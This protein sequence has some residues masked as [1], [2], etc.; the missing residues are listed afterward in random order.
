[1]NYDKFKK[2][3]EAFE[4]WNSDEGWE[5]LQNDLPDL[6]RYNKNNLKDGKHWLK[7]VEGYDDDVINTPINEA[8]DR[9]RSIREDVDRF[10]NKRFVGPVDNDGNF[11][12]PEAQND[13]VNSPAHYT[14]GTQE[15]ID[16]IE[17]AIQDAPDIKAGMLQAQ[18]LKYLL[19][20]WLKGNALQDSAKAQWYLTRLIKHLKENQ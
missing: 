15:V 13:M 18:A 1:M 19:R 9:V 17:E 6:S 16:I 8:V 2:E 3:Y 10:V 4:E 7:I 12:H 14:R 5:Y 11:Y 20:L